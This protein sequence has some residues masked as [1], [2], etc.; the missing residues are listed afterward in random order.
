MLCASSQALDVLLDLSA[1]SCEQSGDGN[2]N[3]RDKQDP[4]LLIEQFE[5]VSDGTFYLDLCQSTWST[6]NSFILIIFC[7]TIHHLV[8]FLC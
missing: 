5:N 6:I 4:G 1:S 8:N 3:L 2:D 7:H